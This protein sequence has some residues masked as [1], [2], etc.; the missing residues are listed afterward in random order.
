MGRRDKSL[1]RKRE[2]VGQTE[3]GTLSDKGR[4]NLFVLVAQRLHSVA[5]MFCQGHSHSLAHA[6]S[7]FSFSLL[8]SM[9]LFLR[10]FFV[11]FF[12]AG[13]DL[14]YSIPIYGF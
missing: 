9:L 2:N 5:A 11:L 3:I 14:C 6:S 1:G 4:Q 10:F 13:T 12:N 8:D 7:P